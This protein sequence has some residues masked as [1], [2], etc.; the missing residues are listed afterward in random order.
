[1]IPTKKEMPPPLTS[2][3]LIAEKMRRSD[4]GR[5]SE[6]MRARGVEQRRCGE[7]GSEGERRW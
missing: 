5:G 2:Q 1:L 4:Q 6:K 7:E 3:T